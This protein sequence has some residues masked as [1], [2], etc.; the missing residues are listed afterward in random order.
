[1]KRPPESSPHAEK[2]AE[3]STVPPGRC[4]E[5][6]RASGPTSGGSRPSETRGAELQAAIDRVTRELA[7]AKGDELRELLDGRREMRR[8]LVEL[9][10]AETPKNVVDLAAARARRA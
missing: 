2:K 6:E 1:L 5:S 3:S 9:R 7:H 10:Q 4:A 8:E